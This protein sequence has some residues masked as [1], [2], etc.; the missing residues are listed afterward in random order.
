MKKHYQPSLLGSLSKASKDDRQSVATSQVDKMTNKSKHSKAQSLVGSKVYSTNQKSQTRNS[1]VQK[2]HASRLSQA[3][4]AI[5]QVSRASKSYVSKAP[6]AVTYKSGG[7][8][9]NPIDSISQRTIISSIRTTTT[10]RERLQD[11][12]RQLEEEIKKR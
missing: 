10:T 6:S 11:I 5:T 9:V 7:G 12:E 1:Q 8:G 3:G 4:Q 2:S